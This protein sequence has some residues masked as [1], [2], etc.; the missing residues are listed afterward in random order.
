MHDLWNK[1]SIQEGGGEFDVEKKIIE[2]FIT[3]K[4]LK[5]LQAFTLFCK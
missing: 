1:Q 4:T 5:G 2:A 3:L